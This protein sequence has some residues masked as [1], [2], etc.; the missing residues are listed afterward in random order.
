MWCCWIRT[1]ERT[2]VPT[3]RL[4][5]K[6]ELIRIR[7][8]YLDLAHWAVE[9]PDRWSHW[10]APCPI[11]DTEIQTAK[12]AWLGRVERRRAMNARWASIVSV[13]F[14]LG[15]ATPTRH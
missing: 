7:A 3:P 8:F 9:E 6:D 15:Y 1:G 10:V 5:L 4:N 11:T 12:G 2:K 13:G 14:D